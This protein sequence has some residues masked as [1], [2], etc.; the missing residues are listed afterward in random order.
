MNILEKYNRQFEYAGLLMT[1]FIAFRFYRI[2]QN[3]VIGDAP[4][5]ITLGVLIIFEF[6]MVHSGMLMSGL[7][8]KVSF[9]GLIP[10]Y[11]LFALVF[12]FA[13]QDPIVLT[14]YLLV[15]I[16]RMR[17]AFS[18]VPKIV[19]QQTL[20]RSI[21]AGLAYFLPMLLFIFNANHVPKWGMTKDTLKALDFPGESNAAKFLF[22]MPHVFIA[23]GFTYYCLL[24]IIEA[25]ALN[26]RFGVPF[27]KYPKNER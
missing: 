9:Y 17:F 4:E 20:L 7:P 19:K 14:V 15:V 13:A 25:F 8:K 21:L 10:F 23:F 6:I 1:L 11:G 24:S 18:N 12:S 5:I 3:P 26:P 22:E 2:W 27:L 16:N